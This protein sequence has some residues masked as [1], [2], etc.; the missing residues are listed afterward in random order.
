MNR[1]IKFRAWD[2][3]NE[4]MVDQPYLFQ[5]SGDYDK[6][7]GDERFNTPYTYYE[8]WQDVEDGV[9]RPCYVMQFIGLKDKNGKDI[10]KG[11]IIHSAFSDGL[12]CRHII[13]FEEETASFVAEF[14]SENSI[15]PT[16][17]RISK[18][19]IEEFGKEVIGNI[20]ENPELLK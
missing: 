10:Y 20:F 19:W 16:V 7:Q 4:R 1:E 14:I 13:K 6:I 15:S 8:T 17:S 5:Q 12:P 9:R 3:F 11:D 2:T 18:S